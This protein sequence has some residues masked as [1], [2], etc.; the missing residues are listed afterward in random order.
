M[1][2]SQLPEPFCG[3]AGVP[4]WQPVWLCRLRADGRG[5]PCSAC[6]STYRLANAELIDVSS[7]AALIPVE[8][9]PDTVSITTASGAAA[10]S[11]AR[12]RRLPVL[13]LIR[14]RLLW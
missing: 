14:T 13:A 2:H 8:P 7:G 11:T 5:L 3:V 12:A 1:E 6:W 9:H 4:F 10:V